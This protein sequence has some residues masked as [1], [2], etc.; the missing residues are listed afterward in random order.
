[1]GQPTSYYCSGDRVFFPVPFSLRIRLTASTKRLHWHDTLSSR[2]F[3]VPSRTSCF[4]L[5]VLP[6]VR[7]KVLQYRCS[8][9]FGRINCHKAVCLL[10]GRE[11]SRAIGDCPTEPSRSWR[12]HSSLTL[13]PRMAAAAPILPISGQ[14]Q[15]Y[16]AS[17]SVTSTQPRCLSPCTRTVSIVPSSVCPLR[18]QW[19]HSDSRHG[20]G[21][22]DKASAVRI[23][24]F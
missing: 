17:L 10:A 23:R 4:P 13:P 18:R 1:M 8:T 19:R 20:R 6:P 3:G 7:H 11:L 16:S 2:T 24:R 15:W 9:I 14:V 5:D 22:R 21:I 12:L